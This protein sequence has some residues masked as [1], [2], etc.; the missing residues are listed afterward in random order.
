MVIYYIEVFNAKNIKSLIIEN[1]IEKF[2]LKLI[3]I[4]SLIT[5]GIFLSFYI[6]FNPLTDNQWDVMASV[7]KN[8]FS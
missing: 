6:I 4:I 7:L 8:E 3:K 2:D 1:K 5:P